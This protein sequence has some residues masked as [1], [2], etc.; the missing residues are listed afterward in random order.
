MCESGEQRLP[1]KAFY[2]LSAAISAPQLRL[3]VSDRIYHRVF[4]QHVFLLQ[5]HRKIA[6]VI[7]VPFEIRGCEPCY[8]QMHH[9]ANL[10]LQLQRA[11]RLPTKCERPKSSWQSKC[12]SVRISASVASFARCS[13]SNSE[14]AYRARINHLGPLVKQSLGGMLE[15][16]KIE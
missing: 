5:A 7:H 8:K 12:V 4:C 15:V 3:D 11:T 9:T 6:S 2:L 13:A 1:Q 14:A 10:F 16:E